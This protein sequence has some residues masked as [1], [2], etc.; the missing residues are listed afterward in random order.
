MVLLE[1]TKGFE[2]RGGAEKKL[3]RKTLGGKKD[4]RNLVGK[5]AMVD[6]VHEIEA[7]RKKGMRGGILRKKE[8]NL[9]NPLKNLFAE[10]DRG[11]HGQKKVTK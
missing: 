4:R 3:R 9:G 5:T 6:P 1:G 2:A 7:K 8:N 10:D 11:K